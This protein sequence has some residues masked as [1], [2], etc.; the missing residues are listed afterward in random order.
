MLWLQNIL[1][2]VVVLLLQLL[3]INN[4]YFLGIV[5]PCIYV[6][7]LLALPAE[8]NRHLLLAIGF[9]TGALMDICCNT[10]GAHAAACTLLCFLRPYLVSAIVQEEDRLTGTMNTDSLGR[11]A[12]IKYV[13]ILT[14]LHH[15]TLFMLETFSFHNLILTL[16][17][18][19]LSSLL[20]IALLLTTE[21]ALRH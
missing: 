20:T 3:L 7:F 4:L 8:V 9:A 19:I 13:V 10:F 14:L 17:Q 12:Y 16:T 11:E 2:F 21:F 6:L 15:T 5:H 18:I 1:R